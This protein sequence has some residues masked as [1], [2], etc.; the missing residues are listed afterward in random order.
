M[1]DTE[2]VYGPGAFLSAGF[3]SERPLSRRCHDNIRLVQ[4]QDFDVRLISQIDTVM[5]FI[6][7][8]LAMSDRYRG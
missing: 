7:N 1:A 8:T 5:C 4:S 6:Y 2:E 3:L